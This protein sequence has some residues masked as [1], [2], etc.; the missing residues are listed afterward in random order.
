MELAAFLAQP[1]GKKL[2]VMLKG[3][4]ERGM[5]ASV[6]VILLN[7]DGSSAAIPGWYVRL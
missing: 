3:T 2:A 5:H 4:A 7:N 1:N 6:N